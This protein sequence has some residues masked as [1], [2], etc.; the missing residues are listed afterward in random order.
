MKTG[1]SEGFW[2]SIEKR[3]G[4]IFEPEEAVEKLTKVVGE[5]KQDQRGRVWDWQGN[6]VLP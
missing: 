4:H 3:Q 5:L 1:L 6:E 2:E